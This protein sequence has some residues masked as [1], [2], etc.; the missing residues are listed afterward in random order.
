ML[1]SIRLKNQRIKSD[2]Y[3]IQESINEIDSK[4]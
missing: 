4:R 2:L 1:V 3:L